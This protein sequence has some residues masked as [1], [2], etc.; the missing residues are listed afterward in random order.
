MQH[1]LFHFHIRVFTARGLWSEEI[2][3]FLLVALFLISPTSAFTRFETRALMMQSTAPGATT[4]YTISIGYA[5]PVAVGS[6][7]MLFCMDPIPYM[8][9]D[10]P[11]GLDVSHATLSGQTGETG[12]TIAT[13]SVNHIVLTRNPSVPVTGGPVSSY[14]FD[15]IVNPTNTTQ[16]F[17]I[18]LGSYESTNASGTLIDGG[19]VRGQVT[20]AIVLETQV[21]PMLIFCLA[22]EVADNC[23]ST[24]DTYYTDMGN[25]SP[26]QTLTAESQMGVG[27]NASQGFTITANGGPPAAGTNVIAGSTQ[28]TASRQGTN[29]FGINL[30]ANN[31]PTVGSDPIGTFANAIASPD[32]STPNEYKYVP[33]DVVA[34]SPNVSLMKK[35]TVSYILNSNANL[36]PGVYSTTI[37]FVASGR[38]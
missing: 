6:L 23:S 8:P 36:H 18:R 3:A 37:T 35:F 10:P 17:S 22:R 2:V 29:Q 21:P 7:D 38:F 13:Q 16:A 1:K 20:D 33:G 4:S 34:Y 5:T 24:D 30:V 19:S 28:P 26:T 27:T 31:E 11:A 15:N 25:L 32:Y 9:C 12:Y 14:T